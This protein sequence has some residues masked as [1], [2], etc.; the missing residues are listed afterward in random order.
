MI[1]WT[2]IYLLV[3]ELIHQRC[4]P[5]TWIAQH[6]DFQKSV[7][8]RRHPN[9]FFQ[10]RCKT[11]NTVVVVRHVLVKYFFSL[12]SLDWLCQKKQSAHREVIRVGALEKCT[13]K[14]YLAL[15]CYSNK[16]FYLAAHFSFIDSF[17]FLL[18]I[19][20]DLVEAR[21]VETSINFDSSS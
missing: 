16:N 9:V 15:I 5:D 3:D 20:P 7:F 19:H 6:D 2:L 10:I 14:K 12:V 4:F 18:P 21:S 8:V 11:I 1:R 13:E 17:I